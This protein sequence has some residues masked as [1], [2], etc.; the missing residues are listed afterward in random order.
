MTV[1]ELIAVLSKYPGDMLV[2]VEGGGTYLN[3]LHEDFVV[4]VWDVARMTSANHPSFYGDYDGYTA[5][6]YEDCSVP[7]EPQAVLLASGYRAEES[8]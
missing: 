8:C 4:P 3:T 7:G 5:D 6:C 1:N 2:L